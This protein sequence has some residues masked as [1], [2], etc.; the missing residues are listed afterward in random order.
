MLFAM[1]LFFVLMVLWLI[2]GPAWNSRDVR[3]IGGGL[4]PWLCVLI[5][6]FVVFGNPFNK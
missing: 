5:L 6:G 2:F 1:I 4:L 3:A